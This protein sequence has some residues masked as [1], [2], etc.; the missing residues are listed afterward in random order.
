[1]KLIRPVGLCSLLLIFAQPGVAADVSG[2]GNT[3]SFSSSHPGIVKVKVSGP[4]AHIESGSLDIY[5]ENPLADGNYSY[6]IIAETSVAGQPRSP[7]RNDGRDYAVA[8]AGVA[9]SVVE[10][11]FFRVVGGGVE[12]G[13][14]VE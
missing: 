8:P 7:S 12:T 11:G 1:M 3:L 13:Q 14:G 4:D 6:E 9:S 10:S 5:L 2:G